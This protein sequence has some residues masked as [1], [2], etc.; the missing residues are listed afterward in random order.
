MIQWRQPSA[1]D[2]QQPRKNANFASGDLSKDRK[3]S[4]ASARNRV[5]IDSDGPIFSQ[6]GSSQSPK[7][8]PR[9]VRGSGRGLG[10]P[11]LVGVRRAILRGLRF[12]KRTGA[13]EVPHGTSGTKSTRPQ[14][15]WVA[16][17]L[18][19]VEFTNAAAAIMAL[20]LGW[21]FG[22]FGER[23]QRAGRTS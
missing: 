20:L 23:N 9:R 5:K 10:N 2:R 22:R 7:R 15:G 16:H 11:H 8:E 12:G 4:A 17:G 6:W 1:R 21:L 19:W 13:L 3:S 14:P 18:N